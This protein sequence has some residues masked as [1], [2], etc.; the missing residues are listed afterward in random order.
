[1]LEAVVQLSQAPCLQ[2]PYR[3]VFSLQNPTTVAQK[4]ART[5]VQT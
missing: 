4:E 1:M 2:T 3:E 5:A